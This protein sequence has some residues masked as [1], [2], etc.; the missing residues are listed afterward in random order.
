MALA[1]PLLWA[2]ALWE[3]SSE[4]RPAGIPQ[5]KLLVLAGLMFAGDLAVWHWSLMLTSVAHA[6]LLA[7]L[8]PVFVTLFAW[9][10]WKHRP[11]GRF[12][13][14]MVA[15]VSGMT[16]M[17]GS[18]TAPPGALLGDALGLVT[19]MF[20]AGYLLTVAQLRGGVSTAAIMAWSGTVTAVILLPL[21]LASGEQLM[22]HTARGWL[23]LLGLAMIAQVAGQSLIAYAMAQL[24]A[25][26]VSVSLLLQ[27]VIAAAFA[28]ILLGEIL[29][30]LQVAGALLVL[31]GIAL[32]R[33]LRE[34]KARPVAAL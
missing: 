24:R 7:N 10:L 30:G 34:E 26:F 18:V 2:W 14:G 9:L 22:P 1:L 6:T 33:D 16:L 31:T 4:I 23:V 21:A 19:A 3:R 5:R 17:I 15:A 8:A 27:P 11:R 25:T 13:I 28:W 20:Y 32:A 29:T 12:V